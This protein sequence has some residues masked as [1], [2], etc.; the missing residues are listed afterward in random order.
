MSVLAHLSLSTIGSGGFLLAAVICECTCT[1]V[2][3]HN[4][5]WGLL[6]SGSDLWLCSYSSH[7]PQLGLGL[8]VRAVICDCACTPATR[9]VW[10]WG[11]CHSGGDLRVRSY[12]SCCIQGYGTLF[13]LCIIYFTNTEFFRSL[14]LF[15]IPY[16]YF[17]CLP[18]VSKSPVRNF[19]I[20]SPIPQHS[21]RWMDVCLGS[22]GPFLPHTKVSVHLVPIY[23]CWLIYH[24]VHVPISIFCCCWY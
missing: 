2:T 13:I 15:A 1:P 19:A 10:F 14:T 17:P 11:L 6:I 18:R 21:H 12:S 16:K 20:D 5:F 4:W 3:V 9:H 22:S 24:Y 23:V 7:C 8:F